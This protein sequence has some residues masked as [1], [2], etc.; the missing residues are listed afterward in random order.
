MAGIRARAIAARRRAARGGT[1]NVDGSVSPDPLSADVTLAIKDAGI[2]WLQPYLGFRAQVGGRLDAKLAVSGPL[3][4]TPRLKISGDAGLRALDISDGQRSVL[5]TNRLRITGIDA[6][7]PER[8]VLDRV[9][10]RRSW[11]LIQRDAEGRFLL[12]TLL[13]RPA[14]SAP[15]PPSAPSDRSVP[16]LRW[17]PSIQPWSSRSVKP[18]SKSRPPPSSTPP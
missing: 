11:A 6:M 3:T 1:L 15:S 16:R 13:E 10:I 14:P 9:R 12:R 2:G 17:R 4:P 5:T 18:C 7:W 8:I